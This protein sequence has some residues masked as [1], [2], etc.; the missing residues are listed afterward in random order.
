MTQQ[1]Q[2]ILAILEVSPASR[3]ESAPG[4]P[5]IPAGPEPSVGPREI[6][7][8]EVP[9]RV[10]RGEENHLRVH[11]HGMSRKSIVLTLDEGRFQIEDLGQHRGVMIN[12]SPLESRQI[13][14]FDDIITFP[15]ADVKLT[16]RRPIR[17][18]SPND[19]QHGD[20]GK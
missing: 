19:P 4:L 15:N 14:R 6:P 8:A 1:N 2:T 3:A 13:V 7:V 11:D 12:G 17:L 9:F 20:S 18:A 5:T 10:G 16:L